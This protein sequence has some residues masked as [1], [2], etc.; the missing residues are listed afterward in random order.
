MPDDTI[1][2][3]KPDLPDPLIEYDEAIAAKLATFPKAELTEDKQFR[4]IM[5]LRA[6]SGLGL[7]QARSVVNSYYTRH[8][9]LV[10]SRADRTRAY[11]LVALSLITLASVCLS[12][13]LDAARDEARRQHRPYAEI[14]TITHAMRLN[15]LVPLT[16]AVLIL[17]FLSLRLWKR[18]K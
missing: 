13:F 5:S 8:G 3:P 14:H 16:I 10:N 18:R 9:M 6:E 15:A 4:L 11:V 7:R 17:S 12:H 2:P 1:W